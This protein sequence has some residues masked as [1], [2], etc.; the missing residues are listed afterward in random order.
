MKKRSTI[1]YAL[2]LAAMSGLSIAGCTQ[3]DT[4]ATPPGAP[5]MLMA[6]SINATTI[7]LMWTRG[8]ND[9]GPDSVYQGATLL[10]VISGTGSAMNVSSLQEQTSYTFTVR[11]AGGT[12]NAVT[13]MTAERTNGLR[14]YETADPSTSD[15]SGLSVGPMMASTI[16]LANGATADFVL[17]SYA[18]DPTLP[19]G[20]SLVSSNVHNAAWRDTKVN[21]KAFYVVGGLNNNFSM[22]DYKTSMD[23]ATM[24]A[25]DI[26]NDAV[27]AT[28]GSAIFVVKTSDNHLALVEVV[29]DASG[30]LYGTDANSHKYV[31]VNVSYQAKVNTGYASRP[32]T[33]QPVGPVVRRSAR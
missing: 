19:S 15:P 9:T 16:N 23:T 5:G 28:K 27:Y 1:F 6:Q 17:E 11:T 10:N 32:H 18:G 4:V 2:A 24:N 13:W 14:I 7:G 22:T 3:T 33:S 8:T 20:I 26:P 25:F 29:P 30:K 31:T 12:T 21:G